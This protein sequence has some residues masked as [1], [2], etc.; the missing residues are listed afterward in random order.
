MMKL[1]SARLAWHDALYTRWDNQGSHVEQLG[2]LGASIQKTERMVCARHAMHQALS[3][4]IQTAIDTLPK[5]LK[6]FGN[7]MYSPLGSDAERDDCREEAEEA[8][9]VMAYAKGPKMMAKKFMRARYVAAAAL[10]RYRRQH[11][12]GQSE[13]NDPLPTPESFRAWLY[14]KHGVELDSR[15]WEREWGDFVQACSDACNDLD[16]VALRPVSCAITEMKIAA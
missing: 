12:G 14:N 5:H 11:Q 7:H 8:V 6:N 16:K 13:G 4:H 9:F 2:M 15:N 3:A 1:N 10:F